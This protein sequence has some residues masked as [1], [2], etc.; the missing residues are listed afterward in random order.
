MKTLFNLIKESSNEYKINDMVNFIKNKLKSIDDQEKLASIYKKIKSLLLKTKAN[1][2]EGDIDQFIDSILDQKQEKGIIDKISEIIANQFDNEE[3]I[4]K[5]VDFVK[6]NKFNIPKDN[7]VIDYFSL[8]ESGT[9]NY[10]KDFV[11]KIKQIFIDIANVDIARIGKYEF[12][13]RIF[14]ENIDSAEKEDLTIEKTPFEVKSNVWAVKSAG[15]KSAK[16]CEIA[17]IE[18]LNLP[19][20]FESKI[21]AKQTNKNKGI[22]SSTPKIVEFNEFLLN[23]ENPIGYNELAE[24]IKVLV[25]K[26]CGNIEGLDDI[27]KEII[28]EDTKT[29]RYKFNTRPQNKNGKVNHLNIQNENY[30]EKILFCADFLNLTKH[31]HKNMLIFEGEKSISR[32]NKSLTSKCIYYNF[33]NVTTFDKMWNK[34]SISTN[35]DVY[36]KID[37][38]WGYQSDE[39][40]PEI[41]QSLVCGAKVFIK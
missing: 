19:Q 6:N 38:L 10:D 15:A 39:D 32:G 35:N 5:F 25:Y 21:I 36:F 7:T 22:F 20:K 18:K 27:L 40:A 3:D 33:D 41:E 11:N 17:F 23:L 12:A 1:N 16:E 30:I 24:G 9:K 26:R 29:K 28:I 37:S 2:D 4:D 8:I 31:D 14:F 13:L 34:I